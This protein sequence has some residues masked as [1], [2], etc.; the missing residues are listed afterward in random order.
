MVSWKTSSR[1]ADFGFFG[2]LLLFIAYAPP[3][4]APPK[5]RQQQQTR[6]SNCHG[7]I[8][9]P[10][11]EDCDGV[12]PEGEPESPDINGIVVDKPIFKQS[13]PYVPAKL[14]LVAVNAS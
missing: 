1:G 5:Q 7:K 14:D 10:E 12:E 2:F 4:I 6:R 9:D 13:T 8:P 11:P 3:P